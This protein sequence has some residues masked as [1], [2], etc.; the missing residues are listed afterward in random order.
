MPG[1]V[2][3]GTGFGCRVHVPAL[4]AAGFDVVALVGR[5]RERTE[6]RAARLGV[7]TAT[8]DLELALGLDGVDAVS[9]VTPPHTHASITL[10]ALGAGKHVLCEKP[11]ALNHD[12][13]V[14]MRDAAALAGRVGLV[15]HEFRFATDRALV[16]RVIA[17]GGVGTPRLA[18]FVSYVPLAA[19][20]STPTPEWWFDPERG[21]GWLGASGSHAVDQVR[22]WLGE[23]ESVSAGLGTTADRAGDVAED[24]FTAYLRMTSGADV[25]IQQTAGAWGPVTMTARVAGTGGTV[26][27]EGTDVTVADRDHPNGMTVEPPRDLRLPEP[28]DA[29]DDP[30]HR[31]THLELGPSIRQA[32][33]LLA[34]IEGAPWP[35][36][37]PATFDDGVAATVVLDA[38][39]ASAARSGERVGIAQ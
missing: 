21:G 30:R 13:A 16:G 3:V 12:E 22:S 7:P 24:T 31:F 25:V 1:A 11:F 6:R 26:W 20:P 36:P 17:A 23:V 15:G 35:R 19:D 5:D 39:R 8:T 33:A 38:I 4:R 28:P 2:V 32:E 27:I 10:A 34:A 29:S 18:T 14:A 37:G 9:V